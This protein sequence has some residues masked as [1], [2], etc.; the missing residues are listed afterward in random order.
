M[1][2]V[3]ANVLFV[4]D[5]FNILRL[6]TKLFEKEYNVVTA[7]CVDDA[8]KIMDENEIDVIVTDYEMPNKDGLHMLEYVNK[9]FSHVKKIMM[10]GNIDRNLVID[11]IN[12]GLVD[13]FVS[14]PIKFDTLKE[15]INDLFKIYLEEKQNEV[16]RVQDGKLADKY[17]ADI[18]ERNQMLYD[19]IHTYDTSKVD[20]FSEKISKVISN[21]YDIAKSSIETFSDRTSQ[22]Q[23]AL[24][25]LMIINILQD[26]DLVASEFRFKAI[27]LLNQLILVYLGLMRND[28]HDNL[29][30]FQRAYGLYNQID[31]KDVKNT[32][33]PYIDELK[34]YL[35]PGF[36][37][38]EHTTDIPGKILSL[39]ESVVIEDFVKLDMSDIKIP[40][41]FPKISILMVL[42]NSLPVY[43]YDTKDLNVSATLASNFIQALTLFSK[44]LFNSDGSLKTIQHESAVILIHQIEKLTYV[45][46]SPIE[47]LQLR[48]AFRE[49]AKQTKERF[50]IIPP[51][52]MI[53]EKDPDLL[54]LIETYFRI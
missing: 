32:V 52:K 4:D 47:T 45:I 37:L 34:Q 40:D 36:A 3:R 16:N 31:E 27:Q 44:E 30:N 24:N 51:S 33:K 46:I 42:N 18:E 26:I 15:V 49:F 19:T 6:L 28:S 48:I 17:R 14:K 21:Y 11:A 38:D 5:Q 13:N 53:N 12:V 7:E 23:E 41:S 2:D 1:E 8:I 54:K 43:I 10:T 39:L 50:S 25:F 29:S 22:D 9:N 35:Q 20:I